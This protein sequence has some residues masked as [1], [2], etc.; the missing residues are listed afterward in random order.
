MSTQGFEFLDTE[1]GN[2]LRRQTTN[3]VLQQDCLIKSSTSLDSATVPSV[4]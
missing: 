4:S 2:K 3:E 1:S